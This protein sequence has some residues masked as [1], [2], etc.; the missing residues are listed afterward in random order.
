MRTIVVV[1]SAILAISGLALV[2]GS[3][4]ESG[5]G[6]SKAVSLGHTWIGSFF[7]VLFPLYAWDHISRNRRWLKQMAW[8][9]ASGVLQ[10]S[11]A[12][13]LVATGVVLLLYGNQV[14][15]LLRAIHHYLTYPFAAAITVH[16][17]ARKG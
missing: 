5:E 14:W 7:L 9:S 3:P 10:T 17:L 11:A 2:F 6:W 15:P 4:G 12:V 1:L 8:V 16:Y 13:V